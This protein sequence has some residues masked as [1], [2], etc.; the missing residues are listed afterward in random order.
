MIPSCIIPY[1]PHIENKDI[2]KFVVSGQVTDN[3]DYQTVSVSMAS[4]IGDPQYIPVSGCYVRIF[5][6]KGNEFVMQESGSGHLQGAGSIKAI[7]FPGL[8]LRLRYLHLTESI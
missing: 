7:S 6:D 4:P 1:E 3:S 5:D 2:N 8:H